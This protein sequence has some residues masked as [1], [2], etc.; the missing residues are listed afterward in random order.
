MALLLETAHVPRGWSGVVHLDLQGSREQAEVCRTLGS[1][2]LELQH[3]CILLANQIT[4]LVQF[5]GTGTQTPPFD[6][7]SF[8]VRLQRA[9]AQGGMDSYAIF[10][11]QSTLG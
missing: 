10:Y 5:H 9:W 6:E 1:L 8:Q 4:G 2:G 3:H 11:N 7:R